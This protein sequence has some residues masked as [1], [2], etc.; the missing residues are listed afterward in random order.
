MPA[1]SPFIPELP[2]AAILSLSLRFL[3]YR[4]DCRE[5]QRKKPYGKRFSIFVVSEAPR[6]RWNIV[7]QRVVKESTDPVR[8]GGVGF[9]LGARLEEM[10]GIETRAVVLGHLQRGGT[11]TPTDRVW[12]PA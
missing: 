5:G 10:T 12:L 1:G 11:P 6:Q 3:R 9:V 4:C 7:V 8:Y 2:A